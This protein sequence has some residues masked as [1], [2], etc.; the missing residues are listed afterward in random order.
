MQSTHACA[1]FIEVT[2]FH[3]KIRNKW[4][5]H[6]KERTKIISESATRATG[7]KTQARKSKMRRISSAESIKYK[8]KIKIKIMP[9]GVSKNNK[10]VK[11]LPEAKMSLGTAAAAG[12]VVS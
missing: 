3:K 7:D 8:L 10:L 12:E 1:C 4:K 5:I 2:L 6:Q 9:K 11:Q